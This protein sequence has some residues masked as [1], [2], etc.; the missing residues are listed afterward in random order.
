MIWDGSQ[1]YIKCIYTYTY[2]CKFKAIK[3]KIWI[4]T[5]EDK[6]VTGAKI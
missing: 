3:E 6:E 2:T 4:K 1:T 5:I